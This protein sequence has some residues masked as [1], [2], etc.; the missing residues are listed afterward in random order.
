MLGT[1]CIT[2]LKPSWLSGLHE[3]QACAY[4][5]EFACLS[6]VMFTLKTAPENCTT[7]F[8][9]KESFPYNLL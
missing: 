2:S 8:R 4:A 7:A 3:G 1:H 5:I 9:S 6:D